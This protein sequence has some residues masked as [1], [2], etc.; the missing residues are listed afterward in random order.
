M[1][2]RGRGAE[3]SPVAVFGALEESAA[4]AKRSSPDPVSGPAENIGTEAGRGPNQIVNH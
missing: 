3:P 4:V 2:N 1:F